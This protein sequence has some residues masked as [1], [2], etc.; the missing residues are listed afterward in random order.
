MGWMN[1]VIFIILAA[2][3]LWGLISRAKWLE[4]QSKKKNKKS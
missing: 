4:D 2:L 3:G 1:L